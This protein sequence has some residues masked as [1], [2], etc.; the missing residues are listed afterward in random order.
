MLIFQKKTCKEQLC[1]H[2]LFILKP[3]YNYHCIFASSLVH[4]EIW[5]KN[6]FLSFTILKRRYFWKM[7]GYPQFYFWISIAVDMIYLSHVVFMREKKYFPLVGTVLKRNGI[8][9]INSKWR[10]QVGGWFQ[11]FFDNKWL[12]HNIT[13]IV[14]DYLTIIPR[15]CVGH[16]LAIIISYPKKRE[17]NIVLLIR[18]LK[19]WLPN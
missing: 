3:C 5:G 1:Y 9:L 4:S 10:I 11:F 7:R 2:L 16:E 13:A 18:P 15:V 8:H 19:A 14:K 6:N 17:W 12:H